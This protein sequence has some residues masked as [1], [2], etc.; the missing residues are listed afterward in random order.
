MV[1][2]RSG[3]GCSVIIQIISVL[4]DV[5]TVENVSGIMQRIPEA[6]ALFRALAVGQIAG[7]CDASVL[8]TAD[9]DIDRTSGGTS[10]NLS[11][12]SGI[13]FAFTEL[14]VGSQYHAYAIL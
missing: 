11:D 7:R 14:T 5:G 6:V 9:R 2:I 12:G 13:Q 3:Y 10:Q 8:Y 4:A 1:I